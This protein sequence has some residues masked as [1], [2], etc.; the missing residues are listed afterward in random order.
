M[1]DITKIKISTGVYWVEIPEAQLYVLC[2]CPEDS[3]KHIKKRGLIAAREEQGIT[4]ETGPN[5]I[6]LSDVLIQNG[7]FSNLS[8]FPVLQMLYFQGMILP[9]HPGNTGMKP[10][11]IG[12][13]E[14]VKSQM[15]YIYRGNYG[16]ISEEEII[17]T[18]V[19]P[20]AAREMMR[21]KLK[22]AFGTIRPTEDLL[23]YRIVE[24]NRVE[25]RN[26]VFISRLRVNVF[27]FHYKNDSVVVD[28]NL[29]PH[30]S[31]EP[32]Y[33]LGFHNIP[34]E[35]FAVVHTGEGDGWDIHRPCMS[36]LLIFQGKLYLIDA[37]PNVYHSLNALGIGI[38]EIEGVF[39][40][41]VHDDHFAGFMTL[42]RSDHKI[43]Y[44]TTPLVRASVIKK[45]SAFVSIDEKQFSHY[46][47]IH[48]LEMEAWNEIKGLEVKPIFSPHPVETNIFIFR[49]MCEDGYRSYAHFADIVSL[50]V[51]SK[52]ITEDDSK[53]GIS[54]AYF[55]KIKSSYLASS[56]LKKLDIGGGLIH[57]AAEDF[58]DDVS[59]KII[60]AH[61]ADELTNQQKTI[62]S[63]AAF[64]MTDV[65]QSGHQDYIRR[66]AF[67]YLQSSFP[68]APR[69]QID[70][71][72]NNP[73]VTFN[74]GS[75]I[76]KSGETHKYIYLILTGDV[77]TI[78]SESGVSSIMSAGGCA[79]E[80]SGLS[81]TAAQ[82]TYRAV[83]FV[84]TLQVP[85]KL[86]L[87]FVKRNG[88]YEEINRLQERRVFLRS[89]WLFGEGISYLHRLLTAS[90]ASYRLT[91]ILPD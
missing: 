86:C 5:A 50:D 82:E 43:K 17:E 57:G 22:F 79:G 70:M 60:L 30:E 27:E 36:S 88:L 87:E 19:S 32:T 71:V 63:G 54:Q 65:L 72:L 13:E 73:V 6:L 75:I 25:I 74:P 7:C 2:G 55:E 77:E 58:K 61:T 85:S 37:G 39:H 11:L 64:G 41:H 78:Q 48:D 16:L 46:F 40:T 3:V 45:L 9:E 8:E 56:D 21:L 51:L 31:Y 26:G 28:L 10:L 67:L 20:E 23:D 38:N 84:H 66:Y 18:G 52:M 69:D 83:N 49:A 42:M 4:F 53:P 62:G 33:K 1:S 12:S 80:V 44:F 34:R 35:Y 47:E 59:K 76:I 24:N 89:T 90:S 68:S 14:Q 81:E 91:L 15:E 29:K